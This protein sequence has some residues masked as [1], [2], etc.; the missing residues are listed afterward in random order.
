[1]IKKD[2]IWFTREQMKDHFL[3]FGQKPGQA[4]DISPIRHGKT[5][6]FESL[7]AQLEAGGELR[8]IRC[9][10]VLVVG[11]ALQGAPQEITYEGDWLRKLMDCLK[12]SNCGYSET[13]QGA[14]VHYV[15]TT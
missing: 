3:K 1:M 8:C 12:C 7:T 11:K 13:V 15:V 9:D 2:E 10:T 5:E 4:E 6:L 14:N